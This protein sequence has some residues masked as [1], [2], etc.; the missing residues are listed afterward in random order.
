M[1]LGLNCVGGPQSLAMVKTLSPGGHL[2]TY[3]A[4]SKQPLS[5]PTGL[6]IFKDLKFSGFW[7]SRWSDAHAQEKE[8]TVEEILNMTREG[9]FRDVPIQ[10]MRW[11]WGTEG[12]RLKEAVGGTLEGFR[13]GKGVLVF[14][15]T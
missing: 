4:M 10:E 5:L 9:R 8:R 2:V 7:V 1:K 3:G 15:D 11:E 12:E 6:L 13:S 14:G